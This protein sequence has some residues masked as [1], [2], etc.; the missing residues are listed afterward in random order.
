MH[1][2]MGSSRRQ[3][4][5]GFTL[6]EVLVALIVTAV[7]LLGLAKMQLLA[8]S[9]TKEAGSRALI[10]LQAGS[11][12]SAMYANGA[13]WASAAVATSVTA[14]GTVVKGLGVSDGGGCATAKC[15]GLVLAATDMQT[16]ATAMNNQFP[17][18]NASVTCDPTS[19]PVNCTIAVTW[20]EQQKAIGNVEG[21][22]RTTVSATPAT[23]SFSMYVQP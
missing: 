18:Y 22:V 19:L 15:T 7:G 6:I 3:R 9:S 21:V 2:M 20:I 14:T 13:Y 11:L 5:R 10:A 1:I 4:Q 8:M 23:Q 12:A 16:W 17:T